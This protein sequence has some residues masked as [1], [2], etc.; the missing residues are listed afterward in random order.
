MQRKRA[1]LVYIASTSILLFIFF[2][3]TSRVPKCEKV[4]KVAY[5]KTHKCASTTVQNILLRHALANNLNVVLPASGNYLGRGRKYQRAMISNTAWEMAGLEYDIFC[6]HTMWN[7][8][9]VN[10]TLGDGTV[11]ITMLRDPVDVFESL[12]NY[13]GM[14][15]FYHM[16][17]EKFAISPKIGLLARRAFGLL[18]RNQMLY[19]MGLSDRAMDMPDV[20]E[21]KIEKADQDFD[22]VLIAERFQ[23]SM[24]LMKEELCWDI[25]D[26]VNLKLN[27]RQD[28]RKSN[29]SAEARKALE[30][31]L[32][33]DYKL[34]NYFKTK[35]DE[36]LA[37]FD[38]TKIEKEL[39][40]L[41][42]ENKKIKEKCD[43]QEVKNENLAGEK[44]LWGK[45]VFGY[46]AN[47]DIPVCRYLSMAELSL[48]DY[49]RSVQ[50]ARAREA[51]P[52]DYKPI[53]IDNNELPGI[54]SHL[55]SVSSHNMAIPLQDPDS[56]VMQN[57]IRKTDMDKIRMMLKGQKPFNL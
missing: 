44:K 39:K 38:S 31:Y 11:Y 55:S 9:E 1:A 45:G 41:N 17:L 36:K 14:R 26:V 5:L 21:R 32:Q 54:V 3:G 10:K 48:L 52:A 28:Q 27:A 35:F 47:N 49:V 50:G 42:E 12:W 43:L 20:V 2:N 13:S 15:S 53:E 23:E 46:E 6:L 25:S 40:L 57:S 24:I 37:A 30:E 7:Q 33:E 22:L 29:L 4:K 18:G 19:D 34:Y 16:D 8:D 51:M 56:L